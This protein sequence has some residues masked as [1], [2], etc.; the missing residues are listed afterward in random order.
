MA[1][2]RSP[3]RWRDRACRRA[4]DE[5]V[6]R[7]RA[8]DPPEREPGRGR[9]SSRMNTQIDVRHV[10]PAIRVPTL[11]LHHTGD[12]GS[13]RRARA[14][15]GAN[16]IPGA[17]FVEL[18]VDGHGSRRRPTTPQSLDE[19]ERVPAGR[20]GRGPTPE[21]DRVLATVLFTDI[22]D[23]TAHMARARRPPLAGAA[24]A[25]PRARPARARAGPRPRGRHRRRRLLRDLRRPGARGPLRDVDRATASASSGIEVR[26]G[27]H[28]GECELVDGKVAGIAVHTG[29]RVASHAGPG[30]VLVSQHG[31]GSRRRLR[32]RVRGSRR[33]R[34]QGRPR[35]VAR[36]TPPSEPRPRASRSTSARRTRARRRAPTR[37]PLPGARRAARASPP[38][39]AR[40]SRRAG[41]SRAGPRRGS[42]AAARRTRPRPGRSR[43]GRP[44]RARGRGRRSRSARPAFRVT[45]CY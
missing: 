42:P 10:L 45:D 19:I 1:A 40:R 28:T 21:P 14:V 20:A 32:P 41:G 23:S 27:L 37:R 39:R 29:A 17:K 35:R 2:R 24:R 30:E 26:A 43:T 12:H 15:P 13:N 9:P 5:E 25:P 6:A 22:V 11:V 7:A 8:T 38:S 44:G 34:A 3:R 18:P 31:Q 33:P 4:G 16:R 36:S